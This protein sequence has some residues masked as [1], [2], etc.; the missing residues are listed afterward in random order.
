MT[1]LRRGFNCTCTDCQVWIRRWEREDKGWDLIDSM[2][3]DGRSLFSI[4]ER[5]QA[6]YPDILVHN[7]RKIEDRFVQ[8]SIERVA[9]LSDGEVDE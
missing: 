7:Y 2:M 3:N 4:Y 5:L 8:R 6:E 9:V 1:C